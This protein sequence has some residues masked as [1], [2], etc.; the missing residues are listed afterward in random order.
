MTRI[1]FCR[2]GDRQTQFCQTQFGKT[3]F[4]PNPVFSFDATLGVHVV[5]AY[6]VK[7]P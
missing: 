4:L 5:D 7:I 2:E 3:Q 6:P 1:L